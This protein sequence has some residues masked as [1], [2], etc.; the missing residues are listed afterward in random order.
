MDTLLQDLRY[1]LR[2]LAREPIVTL[3]VV[4]CLAPGIG[5]NSAG[6]AALSRLMTSV[7]ADLPDLEPIIFIAFFVLLARISLLASYLPARRALKV[8]P[9]AILRRE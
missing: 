2:L 5:A 7:I 6:A 3:V 1:G 4:L 8:D 9:M